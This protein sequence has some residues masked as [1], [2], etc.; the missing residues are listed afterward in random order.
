MTKEPRGGYFGV[1]LPHKAHAMNYS[2]PT[3]LGLLACPGGERFAEQV[4]KR[5]STIYRRRFERKAQ[6]MAERYHMSKEDVTKKINF[7][8]DIQSSLL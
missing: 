1:T 8:K 4:V 5:L 3:R 2:D 7:E 6:V